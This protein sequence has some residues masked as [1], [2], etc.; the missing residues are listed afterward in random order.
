MLQQSSQVCTIM[1]HSPMMGGFNPS[2]QGAP[3]S[4][5]MFPQF[6]MQKYHAFQHAN[7]FPRMSRKTSAVTAKKNFR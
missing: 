1:E 2:V 4:A 3:L 5:L 6:K 7:P